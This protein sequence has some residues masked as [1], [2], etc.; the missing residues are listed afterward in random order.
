MKFS[1]ASRRCDGIADEF[2]V[3]W[4]ASMGPGREAVIGVRFGVN[5]ERG[6]DLRSRGRRGRRPA[7]TRRGSGCAVGP[8]KAE[9]ESRRARKYENTKG[10]GISEGG[11]GEETWRSR[12]RRRPS[13]CPR[14][15]PNK[16]LLVMG[17]RGGGGDLR[18][19]GRRRPSGC[20]RPAPN[21]GVHGPRGILAMGI[22]RV[23][24]QGLKAHGY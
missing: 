10:E 15:A 11:I 24:Y 19:R 23:G 17:R 9:D 6:G 3:I 13:G 20:P 22:V 2:G 7:R 12:A 21:S 1:R 16:E 8:S 5:G 4:W 18:S 14:P